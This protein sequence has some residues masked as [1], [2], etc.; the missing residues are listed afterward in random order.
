MLKDLNIPRMGSVENARMVAWRIDEGAPFQPGD[1]LYEIETD[2]TTTEV[3][4]EEPGIL[5]RRLAAEGDEFKV[6]DRIGL[7]AA[8]G[9]LPA[10][11][12]QALSGDAA[13]AS[14]A[15][16]PPPAAAHPPAT[17]AGFVRPVARGAAGGARISPLARRLAAQHDIDVAHISGSGAGGRITGDDV[18]AAARAASAILPAPQSAPA[19]ATRA[20]AASA[21]PASPAPA[22][23]VAYQ[24]P[25][26]GE[27]SVVPHTMR[28]RTI[29]R[30]MV[31]SAAIP[32]RTA[33]MEIELTALFAARKR[34]P[35]AS[36][37][38]MV[39]Q[40]TVAVLLQMPQFNAHWR[41]DALVV[42]NTVHLGVAVDTPEGLVVPVIRNA[43]RLNARGL[44]DAIAEL[45]AKARAGKL[46]VAEIEGSTFTISNPGSV[47]PVL[48]TEALINPPEVGILGLPGI[49]RA[50]KAVPDGDG[51][52]TAVRPVLRPSLTFDHRAIDGGPAVEFLNTLKARI[53]A[54]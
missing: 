39:A 9:T 45:A 15:V 20:S 32:T 7:W 25:P 6:G 42:W 27:A 23:T 51:W 37:L 12:E 33:D 30:R 8:P 3:E 2:K 35:G 21:A 1:V 17:A 13:P 26:E 19:P 34:Q 5:A 14:Q 50:V 31:E 40:E 52:A 47:G 48:H 46:S 36:I 11:I 28:R 16:I 38:A 54:L 29:A 49:V 53:E 22:P 4:A 43:E 44:T 10:N 24:A 18:R 41:D